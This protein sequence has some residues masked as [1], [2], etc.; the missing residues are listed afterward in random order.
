MIYKKKCI[1]T[2]ITLLSKVMLFVTL[3][4][5]L[6]LY[7]IL[8][9]NPKDLKEALKLFTTQLTTYGGSINRKKVRDEKVGTVSRMPIP[10]D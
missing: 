4:C 5:Y 10:L 7:K 6:F 2:V 1:V 3:H 8:I 9:T